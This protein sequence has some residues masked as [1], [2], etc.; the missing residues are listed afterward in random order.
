MLWNTGVSEGSGSG[1]GL[2]VS[3]GGGS[4]ALLPCWC[5]SV[6]QHRCVFLA[7]IGRIDDERLYL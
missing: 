1:P 3:R 2:P 5:C 6:S 7:V 4:S